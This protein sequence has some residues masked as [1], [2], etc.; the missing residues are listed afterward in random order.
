M[1]KMRTYSVTF[2]PA[3][4]DGAF[5]STSFV[6]TA[7][8]PRETFQAASVSEVVKKVEALAQGRGGC[9]AYVDAPRGERKPPGF[10]AA[11]AKLYF[12]LD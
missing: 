11:T 3:K 8:Y 1:A 10:D 9:R 12:N 4:R 5:V 6:L 7:N 2:H